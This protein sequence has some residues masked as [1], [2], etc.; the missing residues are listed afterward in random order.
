VFQLVARIASVAEHVD[1]TCLSVQGGVGRIVIQRRDAM[2]RGQ[3]VQTAAC[4]NG[5]AAAFATVV[6]TQHRLNGLDK[7]N[8]PVR[9]LAS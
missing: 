9:S 3:P 2:V 6:V 7:L 4:R 1:A 5:F 8:L